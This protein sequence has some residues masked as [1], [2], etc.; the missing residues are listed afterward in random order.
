M[1]LRWSRCPADCGRD[2][3]VP[4]YRD[5]SHLAQT[6][7]DQ[8]ELDEVIA[9]M[10]S[11]ASR[12]LHVGI[13][14][15]SLARR[16]AAAVAWIDGITVVPEERQL[17]PALPNYQ[18]WLVDKHGP[19]LAGL[20]GSYD[21]VVDNNPGTFACCRRHFEAMFDGYAALLA[22]GGRILT[23]ARGAGWAGAIRLRYPHWVA[24]GRE[25]GL[26][27]EQLSPSVW[28]LLAAGPASR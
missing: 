8:A 18:A 28:A 21:L 15:S 10:L 20:P 3:P 2:L 1:R 6:S 24:L 26:Q 14:S 5:T 4:G 13:G 27:A 9:S 12:V 16:H 7:P 19:G 23:H 25:R 11:P 22:P 17:A